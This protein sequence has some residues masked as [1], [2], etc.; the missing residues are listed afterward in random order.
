MFECV[1]YSS[2]YDSCAFITDGNYVVLWEQGAVM[3]FSGHSSEVLYL[4]W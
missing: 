2:A 3:R 4:L 1:H